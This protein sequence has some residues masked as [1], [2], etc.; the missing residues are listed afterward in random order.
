M[1]IKMNKT[2]EIVIRSA[3]DRDVERITFL[4]EQLGYEVTRSQIQQRLKKLQS[5]ERHVIYVA[6]L[7]TGK[8]VGWIHAHQCDLMIVPTQAIVLGVVVDEN[9][10]R[11]GIGKQLMASIEK[12]ARETNC[13]AVLLRSNILRKEAHIF[14]E[15]IGYSNSK[16]SLV[17]SKSIN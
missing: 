13:D 16:Q 3:D 9:Y 17:F 12:W 11:L 10:R 8:V 5:D 14:Y 6:T 1:T 2:N 7:S 4:C 15:K